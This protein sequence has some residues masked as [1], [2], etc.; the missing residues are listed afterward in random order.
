M[1]IPEYLDEKFF[2][3]LKKEL[4]AYN[5]NYELLSERAKRVEERDQE[6]V[7]HSVMDVFGLEDKF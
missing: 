3:R 4:D 1:R 2:N 6:L 5:N 7:G